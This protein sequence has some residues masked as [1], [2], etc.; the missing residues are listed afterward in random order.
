MDRDGAET[1]GVGFSR[2]MTIMIDDLG[3]FGR[4]ERATCR[5][6]VRATLLL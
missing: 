2:S 1:G 5:F 3:V 6:L 4:C